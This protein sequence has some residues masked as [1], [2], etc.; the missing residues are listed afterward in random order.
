M[1]AEAT[2]SSAPAAHRTSRD[3][4]FT[5]TAGGAC[6]TPPPPGVRAGMPV[7]QARTATWCAW[8]MS[9]R[10]VALESSERRAYYRQRRT[11]LGIGGVD[12]PPPADSLDGRRSQGREA[13]GGSA[14]PTCPGAPASTPPP[15][16]PPSSPRLGRP[17]VRDHCWRLVVLVLVVISLF[18]SGVRT[19]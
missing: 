6:S 3:R 13:E 4:D 19:P 14:R 8:A 10:R 7:E 12:R 11:A 2:S 18:L 15:A 1:R 9:A 5:I 17:R 16:A